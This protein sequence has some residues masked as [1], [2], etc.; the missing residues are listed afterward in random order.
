[1]NLSAHFTLEE[2]TRSDIA[3]RKGIDNTPTDETVGNLTDL[4][5]ALEQVRSFLG[6]PLYVNSAYRSPKVNTAVG[7]SPTSAH[8]RGYAA[9][10]VSPQFGSPKE[11]CMAIME[12]DLPFDQLIFEG[13]WV[14]LSVDPRLRGEVLTAHFGVGGVTYTNGI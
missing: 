8:C 5:A 11:V 9:D 4:A 13:T 10:F 14:H 1:M 12:S 7:G 2:L 3:L 6:F